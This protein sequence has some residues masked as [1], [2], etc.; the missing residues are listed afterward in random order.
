[1]EF[2]C[3]EIIIYGDYIGGFFTLELYIVSCIRQMAQPHIL[4][5]IIGSSSW[6]FV[7]SNG[8][9][10]SSNWANLFIVPLLIDGTSQ[11]AAINCFATVLLIANYRVGL[12]L[13][14]NYY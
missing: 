9:E 3:F 4:I 13:C 2:V 14:G 12:L 8:G 11:G 6:F 7:S 5:T 10:T 1:M